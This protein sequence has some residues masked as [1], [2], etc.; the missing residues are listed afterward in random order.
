MYFF[1]QKST[2]HAKVFFEEL[3]KCRMFSLWLQPCA[4][5]V[6]D[7]H[8]INKNSYLKQSNCP[9][10]TNFHSGDYKTKGKN[11][12]DMIKLREVNLISHKTHTET[13]VH[14]TETSHSVTTVTRSLNG[15]HVLC[16]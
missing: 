4:K 12:S 13:L 14:K 16:P 10:N 6:L 11:L 1:Q 8:Q 9:V 5:K 7:C 15:K 3:H 2:T